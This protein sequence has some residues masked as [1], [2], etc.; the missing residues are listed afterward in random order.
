MRAVAS[1]FAAASR[2]AVASA[3]A[4]S[5]SPSLR[6]AASCAA[7]RR[8]FLGEPLGAGARGGDFGF[9]DAPVGL[10]PG[11]RGGRLG[12][13]QFGRTRRALGG[14][15]R[16]GQPGPPRFLGGERGFAVRQIAFEPRQRLR[17]IAGQPV[18]VAA[19]GFEPRALAVEIGK[20]LLGGF[21]LAGKARHA[22]AVGAGIVAAV[23]QLLARLGERMCRL[24]LARLAR[25]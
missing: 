16:I 3:S 14:V 18:G 13:R 8:R 7:F 24:R 20:A 21:E 4:A 15:E 2:R 12:Q 6:S 11:L 17:R 10:D 25:S 23:G 1:A 22:V 19:I 9:G 5:G